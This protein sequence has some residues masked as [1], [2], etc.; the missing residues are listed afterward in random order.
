MDP[1][2]FMLVLQCIIALVVSLFLTGVIIRR[3]EKCVSSFY[4]PLRE[5]Y[6]RS[7]V[8]QNKIIRFIRTIYKMDTNSSIHWMY[9]VFHY[10]QIITI[11]LSVFVL[12]IMLIIPSCI[13]VEKTVSISMAASL[14]H[15]GLISMGDQMLTC[16]EVSKCKKIKKENPKY[17][18]RDF[19]QPEG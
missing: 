14:G 13:S 16:V 19:Y 11:P 12:L 17:A 5:K 7:Y 8:R 3:S 9:C 15:F 4:Y 2:V 1:N 18:K 10:L 6:P